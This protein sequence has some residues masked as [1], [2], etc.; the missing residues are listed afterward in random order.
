MEDKLLSSG[1][2]V[3]YHS[4]K[5]AAVMEYVK[6]LKDGL[7]EAYALVRDR[8]KTEHKW[9]KSIYDI[10]IHGEP[11]NEGDLVWLYTPAV[12]SGQSQKLHRPWIS[13][14]KARRRHLK[15]ARY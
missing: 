1:S 15:A 10:K 8:Y 3:R 9:Q 12:P 2:D 4:G 13:S 6:N 5:E 7:L 14:G 11:Y